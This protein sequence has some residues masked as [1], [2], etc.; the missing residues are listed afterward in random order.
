MSIHRP[1]RFGEVI[2]H[3]KQLMYFQERINQG[4]FPAFTLFYGEEGLG[5]T[6]IIKLIAMALSCTSYVK[7][8]Y[9]CASCKEITQRVIRENKDTDNVK[10]FKMSVD[11]GKEDIKDVLAS[12]NTSFLK[13]NQVKVVILEECHRMS[14][15]A[16]DALLT[17]TE[18][19][20]KNVYLLMATTDIL[21]LSKTLMS[22]VVPY[23]LNR[24]TNAEMRRLLAAE[25][26]RRGLILQGGNAILD[27]IITWA[28][29]KPRKA[30]KALEAMGDNTQVTMEQIKDHVNFLDLSQ[31]IPIITSINGSLAKGLH[32]IM[33]L[34]MSQS[35][36][37]SL[38]DTLVEAV[39]VAHGEKSFKLTNEDFSLV[40]EAVSKVSTDALIIF[41]HD[42][43]GVKE[44][45]R[46]YLLASYLKVHA[47]SEKLFRADKTLDTLRLE[48]ETR[49]E[50]FDDTDIVL[51]Q[52]AADE[53]PPTFDAL[54]KRGKVLDD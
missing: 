34:P 36:H 43:A 41:L 4:N 49:S 31:I 15:A 48:Q 14:D 2:G 54:I 37:L 10:T 19:L 47:S 11:G 24:L 32:A 17:D 8:C 1:E 13:G 29:N 28:E 7:P 18:Y 6:T 46:G 40:R 27:V 50:A 9:E 25:A 53:R 26:S 35:A 5:K 12:L 21:R 16:Q 3:S 44:L 45:T 33:E 51:P 30:L 38:V 52:T 23:N 22:R 42:I 39:K 20:P